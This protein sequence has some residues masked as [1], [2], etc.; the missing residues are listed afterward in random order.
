MDLED[1]APAHA[2]VARVFHGGHPLTAS[3]PPLGIRL[4]FKRRVVDEFEGELQS[5]PIGRGQELAHPC[6]ERVQG[7][8]LRGLACGIPKHLEEVHA[9][10]CRGS[11]LS[12]H[13]LLLVVFSQQRHAPRPIC[14]PVLSGND[15]LI[16]LVPPP[17]GE[18]IHAHKVVGRTGCRGRLA[19]LLQCGGTGL[20]R[21]QGSNVGYGG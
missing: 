16:G 21:R 7:P 4:E 6:V 12:V 20:G 11:D 15:P 8:F 14:P 3:A 18:V 1:R 2:Q 19:T 5:V 17:A 13:G 10:L 9:V